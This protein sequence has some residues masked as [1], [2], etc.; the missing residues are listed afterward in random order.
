MGLLPS[1]NA[2]LELIAELTVNLEQPRVMIIGLGNVGGDLCMNISDH[3]N[4]QN[5]QVLLANRTAV[6]ANK[7]AKTCSFKSGSF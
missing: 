4:F 5:Y 3:K 6:K 1:V 2:T 7:L